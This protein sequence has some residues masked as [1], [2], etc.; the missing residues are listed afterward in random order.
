[1]TDDLQTSGT[2]DET[3]NKG[4]VPV[5]DAIIPHLDRCA[6]LFD[7]DGTLIDLAPTPDSVV[8]P[9]TLRTDLQTLLERTS[10][11]L[12][13]VSGRSLENIA[14]L[15]MPLDLPAV[16][17]HGAEMRLFADGGIHTVKVPPLD[18]HLKRKFLAIGELDPGVLVEDKGYSIA[19][20]YRLVPHLEAT[21]HD[22]VTQIRAELTAAPIEVLGGK[23]VVEIK[24]AGFSKATAVRELMKLAPFS[25]RHPIFLGD[26]ITD[27]TV[28]GIMPDLDGMAFSV[29]RK[30]QGVSGHFDAPTD[31]RAWI[32]ELARRPISVS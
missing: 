19:L 15:M 24:H 4:L 3:P 17:G 6:L 12:A 5:P 23:F 1:M 20:H 11:A 27:E 30:A 16:G 2:L 31:V 22:T 32:A 25:G 9:E 26:D 13:L 21:I 10:G 14:G 8:V 7:I 18:P 28:F 29:G